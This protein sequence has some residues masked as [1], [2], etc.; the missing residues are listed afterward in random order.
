MIIREP[1]TLLYLGK[2][3]GGAEM[4]REISKELRASTKFEVR[5]IV[6]RGDNKLFRE[7]DQNKVIRLFDS[8]YSLRS[9]CKLMYFYLRPRVLLRRLEITPGGVCVVPMMS[10]LGILVEKIL[11]KKEIRILRLIHD[12]G[13]HPGDRWPST[14]L[15]KKIIRKSD[16]VICLSETVEKKI[17][18]INPAVRTSVYTHPIFHFTFDRKSLELPEKFFLFIGRIREY[19]G[20]EMLVG[21]YASLASDKLPLVIAGE[22]RINFEIPKK[23][24]LFNR[25]LTESEIAEFVFRAEVVVFPYLEASQ[26]GLIPYCK[27]LNKKIV[28]TPIAGLIEQTKCYANSFVAS[29]ISENELA[30]ALTDAENAAALEIRNPQN[31]SHSLLELCLV[32]SGYFSAV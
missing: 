7:F 4:T 10:P 6:L 27:K 17:I 26:S 21:A 16:F 22:G 14:R 5:N 20:L 30:K 11:A 13:R 25:W 1:V 3:G 8:G 12:A 28:V 9:L 23:S 18:E 15:I 2:K 24:L 29:D 19:K 32:N 31:H